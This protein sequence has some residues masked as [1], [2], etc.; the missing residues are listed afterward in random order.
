MKPVFSNYMQFI[1]YRVVRAE[2]VANDVEFDGDREL[3]LQPA[4][5]RDVRRLG[6]HEYSILIGIMLGSRDGE[7]PFP[8]YIRL[9]I[10]GRFFV[11]DEE[12]AEILMNKN[13]S[14]ILFPYLRSTLTMLTSTAN[15]TPIILPTLNFA[16]MMD[17][18]ENGEGGDD[19]A[20]GGNDGEGREDDGPK[21]VTVSSDL[22]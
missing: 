8:F 11:G 6:D 19:G 4:F 15:I 12:H 7:S 3:D 16:A 2:Y 14:A 9:E 20:E 5:T 13:A 21:V 17:L 18:R 1:S 10:E 22:Q